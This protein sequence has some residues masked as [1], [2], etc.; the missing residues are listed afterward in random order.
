MSG[1]REDVQ[2]SSTR[3]RHHLRVGKRGIQPG[4]HEETQ[5]EGV[6]QRPS[7]DKFQEEGHYW[8]YQTSQEMV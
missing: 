8:L 1:H 3:A 5:E 4:R 7:E 2:G 6:T